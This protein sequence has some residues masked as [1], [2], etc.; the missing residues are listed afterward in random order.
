MNERHAALLRK[1]GTYVALGVLAL[2]AL[3]PLWWMVSTSLKG[4]AQIYGAGASSGLG[5]L[6]TPAQWHNYPAALKS[7]PFEHYLG[8]TLLLCA[9]NVVCATGS[10]ALVAYG[11]A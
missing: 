3:A 6:P 8:N 5:L 10:S 7:V 4:D 11:F 9:L 1:G 2:P